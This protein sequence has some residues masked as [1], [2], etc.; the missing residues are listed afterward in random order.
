MRVFCS[1]ASL[2]KS[3][4]A[5]IVYCIARPVDAIVSAGWGLLQLARE[6]Q[7]L[8]EEGGRRCD[9]IRGPNGGN[10]KQQTKTTVANRAVYRC[11]RCYS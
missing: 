8:D 10:S 2:L 11:P 6:A 9:A 7:K 5:G 4:L 3:S 1:S